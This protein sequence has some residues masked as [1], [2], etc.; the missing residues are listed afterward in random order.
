MGNKKNCQRYTVGAWP[1]PDCPFVDKILDAIPL[2]HISLIK[3]WQV[4]QHY[5]ATYPNMEWT[6]ANDQEQLPAIAINF[7]HS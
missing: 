5:Q 7:L 1:Q 3:I 6:T 2:L 4:N